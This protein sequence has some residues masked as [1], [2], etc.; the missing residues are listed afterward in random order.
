MR[1]FPSGVWAWEEIVQNDVTELLE[2]ANW[3]LIGQAVCQNAAFDAAKM[4]SPLCQENPHTLLHRAARDGA[5]V[6]A[7]EKLVECGA[8]RSVRDAQGR[9][10]VD[11]ARERGHRHLLSILE[12]RLRSVGWE[13]PTGLLRAVVRVQERLH[14]HI[15][16]TVPNLMG[17]QKSW[18]PQLEPLLEFPSGV[19]GFFTIPGMYGGFRYYIAGTVANT[20]QRCLVFEC[21]SWTVFGNAY[22]LISEPL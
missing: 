3:D 12:P 17:E 2:L 14:V 16:N 18:L 1:I 11:V 9:R 20:R 21:E 15:V 7:V 22:V 13:L 6:S 19:T 10:P 5:S 4:N 8:L